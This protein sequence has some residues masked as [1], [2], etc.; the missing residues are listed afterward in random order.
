MNNKIHKETKIFVTGIY[1]S[2]KTT[3]AKQYAELT[4]FKYINFDMYFSYASTLSALK[5]TSDE[6]FLNI[7]STDFITDAIPWDPVSGSASKFI[8]FAKEDSRVLIVCCVCPSKAEWAKRLIECKKLEMTDER[9]SHY[10][11]YYEKILPA[12]HE[13]NIVYYDTVT[14]EFI[15]KEE[16]YNKIAWLSEFY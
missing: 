12:Y 6:M 10:K 11:V 4:G 9:Y 16:L 14:N 2:G 5:H 1:G 13:L 3:Y 7:L 15:T 8:D